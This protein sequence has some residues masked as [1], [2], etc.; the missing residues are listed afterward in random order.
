M[1]C[2][3]IF[4]FYTVYNFPSSKYIF[5][6]RGL[7]ANEIVAELEEGNIGGPV[8]I[9][10]MPPDDDG[11]SDEDSD[12]EDSILPKDPNHLGGGILAQKAELVVYGDD[13]GEDEAGPAP[14]A[15]KRARSDQDEEGEEYNED[16]NEEGNEEDNEEDNEMEEDNQTNRGRRL[17]RTKNTDRRWKNAKP[18][19]FGMSVPDFQEQPLKT[20]PDDCD[21]PY[22]F[23]KLFVTDEFVDHTVETS[24]HY[25][26][27]NGHVHVQPKL[28]HNNI[29]ITHAI[30]YMTGYITPSNR[31]MYWEKREDS[32]NSL[33]A[34]T[35][36]EQTFTNIIRNTTFVKIEE[37]SA[38][39]KDK[40]KFWKVW[41]LYDEINKCAKLWV[42]HPEKVSIDEGMVKY[43]G[44]HPLKQFMRGKPHRF[45]YKVGFHKFVKIA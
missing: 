15:K 35:M 21:S 23:F 40:D 13:D 42:K 33:V 8:D 32:R 18:K 28:T 7:T 41:P 17:G 19:I 29:R 24:I 43:F 14:K 12:D 11:L 27:T 22:D 36:S 3:I 45:G 34:K 9:I 30:M 37:V 39:D 6:I 20:L 5:R 1:Y 44:P 10:L 38:E 26:G 25:A 31:R 16:G 4:F 2:E